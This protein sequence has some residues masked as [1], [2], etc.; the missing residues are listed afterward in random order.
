MI[1][2]TPVDGLT[3][4]HIQASLTEL[5]EI[6]KKKKKK[7]RVGSWEMHCF[8]D[9][10]DGQGGN[11]KTRIKIPCIHLGNS[12]RINKN[13]FKKEFAQSALNQK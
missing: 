11:G 5:R 4:M 13:Y 1:A 3:P 2:Q 7:S 12:Q 6:F 8:L 10:R 9:P